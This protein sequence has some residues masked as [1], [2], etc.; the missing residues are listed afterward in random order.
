MILCKRNLN[1]SMREVRLLDRTV[2]D[3]SSLTTRGSQR[4]KPEGK[5]NRVG[6]AAIAEPHSHDLANAQITC[7]CARSSATNRR[8]N[9]VTIKVPDPNPLSTDRVLPPRAARS[10]QRDHDRSSLIELADLPT[11]PHETL[12][13]LLRCPEAT[14]DYNGRWRRHLIPS[15]TRYGIRQPQQESK[16]SVTGTCRVHRLT[17]P[18]PSTR[19]SPQLLAFAPAEPAHPRKFDRAFHFYRQLLFRHVVEHSSYRVS[20]ILTLDQNR[21]L[22]STKSR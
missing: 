22:F 3:T 12:H 11:R 21:N 2:V 13:L 8:W 15:Q 19:A 7:S 17:Y 5:R 20:N 18:P 16:K 9:T 6:L 14:G 10:H 1:S 4:S